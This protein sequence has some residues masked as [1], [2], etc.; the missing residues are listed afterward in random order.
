M[1]ELPQNGQRHDSSMDCRMLVFKV[2]SQKKIVESEL[3]NRINVG[4]AEDQE[5][6]GRYSSP[7]QRIHD[8]ADVMAKIANRY[9]S[10]LFF[11]YEI[12]EGY[13]REFGEWLIE[14]FAA[15]TKTTGQP[16]DFPPSILRTKKKLII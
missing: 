12:E 9:N 5:A 8:L 3:K 14:A 2:I 10:R 16:W 1:A 13:I 6:I 4:R 11:H 15:L 7:P